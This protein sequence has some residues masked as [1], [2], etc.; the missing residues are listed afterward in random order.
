MCCLINDFYLTTRTAALS[1]L[2]LDYPHG[3]ERFQEPSQPLAQEE[4]HFGPRGS[5]GGGG[6]QVGPAERPRCDRVFA[7]IGVYQQ[8]VWG[9]MSRLKLLDNI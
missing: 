8:L 2:V 7:T 1:T 9:R 6:A 5:Y 3:L 4:P